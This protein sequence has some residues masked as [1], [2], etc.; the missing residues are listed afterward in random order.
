MLGM[1]KCIVLLPVYYKRA[2][3][4]VDLHVPEEA[5]TA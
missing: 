4:Q 2:P 5:W 3:E 1:E